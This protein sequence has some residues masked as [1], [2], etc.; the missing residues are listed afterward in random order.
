MMPNGMPQTGQIW[1]EKA[2][3][4][5]A[6]YDDR[7]KICSNI[8]ETGYFFTWNDTGTTDII[9]RDFCKRFKYVSG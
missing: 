3:G 9:E 8:S 5:L 6:T 4:K 2:T 1:R 7:Y